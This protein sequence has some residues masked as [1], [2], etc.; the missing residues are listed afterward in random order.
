MRVS[1]G[2]RLSSTIETNAQD[3]SSIFFSRNE[4][5]NLRE[6]IIALAVELGIPICWKL[7]LMAVIKTVDSGAMAADCDC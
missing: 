2:Q 7:R 3:P 4:P 6:D 5:G 1:S